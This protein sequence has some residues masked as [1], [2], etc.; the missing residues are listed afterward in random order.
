[1]GVGALENAE[2]EISRALF[3]LCGQGEGTR[4]F[5]KVQT[6]A[7]ANETRVG[8]SA[9]GERGDSEVVRA[10][11]VYALLGG[12]ATLVDPALS[13][14]RV[15]T[16]AY[17]RRAGR[18]LLMREL[19]ARAASEMAQRAEKIAKVKLFSLRAAFLECSLGESDANV[20][21]DHLGQQI[22]DAA[23][24]TQESIQS[25]MKPLS[26]ESLPSLIT[27]INNR[28]SSMQECSGHF[29]FQLEAVHANDVGSL[30]IISAASLEKMGKRA[31]PKKAWVPSAVLSATL[32]RTESLEEPGTAEAVVEHAASL[33]RLSGLIDT[34]ARS[35]GGNGSF[36]CTGHSSLLLLASVQAAAGPKPPQGNHVGLLMQACQQL[37][38]QRQLAVATSQ[39]QL[40]EAC[41]RLP[42]TYGTVANGGSLLAPG[43]DRL[44]AAS[45]GPGSAAVRG[46]MLPSPPDSDRMSLNSGSV[47]PSVTS[48]PEL[49]PATLN[50]SFNAAA[51]EA[52]DSSLLQGSA[53]APTGSSAAVAA[54]GDPLSEQSQ[55]L[56]QQ[57]LQQRL[58]SGYGVLPAF[59]SGALL[60]GGTQSTQN[61]GGSTAGASVASVPGCLSPRRHSVSGST[62]QGGGGGVG[63]FMAEGAV[64]LLEQLAVTE[65]EHRFS[66][67]EWT[68]KV[69]DERLTHEQQVQDLLQVI[70]RQQ[71]TQ[72]QLA[73]NIRG[74]LQDNI[75][76]MQEAVLMECSTGTLS[77]GA[78]TGSVSTGVPMERY[79]WMQRLPRPAN[80]VRVE[81]PGGARTTSPQLVWQ[82]GSGGSQFMAGSSPRRLPG[83]AKRSPVRQSSDFHEWASVDNM[84]SPLTSLDALKFYG[85]SGPSVLPGSEPPPSPLTRSRSANFPSGPV[86]GNVHR[87]AASGIGSLHGECGSLLPMSPQ[88][89]PRDMSPARSRSV[90]QGV[91]PAMTA[92]ASA[93]AA[94]QHGPPQ[95]N[96]VPYASGQSLPPAMMP[97]FP[98][99]VQVPA[100]PGA[101]LDT[102][103]V[104]M[105]PR[106]EH[107]VACDDGV[108]S[109]PPAPP[110]GQM[111]PYPKALDRTPHSA[112]SGFVVGNVPWMQPAEPRQQSNLRWDQASPCRVRYVGGSATG[113][114]K[115]PVPLNSG[116]GGNRSVIANSPKNAPSG[117][118]AIGSRNSEPQ[119]RSGAP[120]TGSVGSAMSGLGLAVPLSV[121]SKSPAKCIRPQR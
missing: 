95:R 35:S 39:I 43:S 13:G 92:A 4:G 88:V 52:C 59:S 48:N 50:S 16:C 3:A 12:D 23:G 6:I 5:D 56:Q 47:S 111:L 1:M 37:Q 65:Q 32:P 14:R 33:H 117:A 9:N 60:S 107:R 85:E 105:S 44:S 58:A 2:A 69:R 71:L 96:L 119:Q 115:S 55:L 17:G 66:L 86:L 93:T 74:F 84:S 104:L 87:G 83:E 78:S 10:E 80:S 106:R 15:L 38:E 79:H 89:P 36:Q 77:V 54:G 8:E 42:P 90:M 68:S 70:A 25:I 108:R 103:C 41:S 109:P 63:G 99:P 91:N 20:V 120:P 64:A 118:S 27:L 51:D 34:F 61:A 100:A 112:R 40:S 114:S 24:I 22:V 72:R 28:A 101:A 53:T 26:M 29:I 49:R 94:A 82:Q 46:C 31:D 121:T 30:T 11:A 75:Y 18:H 62:G 97:S 113:S 102:P 57:L 98:P 116:Q 76:S 110:A 81:G 19:A 73:E 7:L 45:G 21:F 67:E